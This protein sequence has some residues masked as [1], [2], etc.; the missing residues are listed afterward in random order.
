MNR[1][2]RLFAFFTCFI[3]VA[4]LLSS[5]YASENEESRDVVY[6]YFD[7]LSN[8]EWTALGQLLSNEEQEEYSSFISDINNA[9]NYTGF[10]NYS[11]RGGLK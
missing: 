2:V 4:S 5:A 7:Y 11:Y 8:N 1:K 3:M 10:F 9:T 6:A